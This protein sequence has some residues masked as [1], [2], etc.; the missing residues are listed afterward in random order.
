MAKELSL[1]IAE[2]LAAVKLFDEFKG[3]LSQMA[4]ILDDVKGFVVTPEEWEKS[5]L[6]KKQNAD[7]TESW[8]WTDEGSEK[9]VTLSQES[10]DYLT[11][12]IKAKSD[13]GELTLADK[14]LISLENKLK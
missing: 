4:M 1:T 3:G 14:S 12:K 2:R 5:N 11:G 8:N 6:V 13:A 9:A 7:G 10:L